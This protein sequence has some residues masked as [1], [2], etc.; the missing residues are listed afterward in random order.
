MSVHELRPAPEVI[1]LHDLPAL[2]MRLHQAEATIH[3]R[4]LWVL[5]ALY[6]TVG[7]EMAEKGQRTR[8]DRKAGVRY[9]LDPPRERQYCGCHHSLLYQCP[10]PIAE[11]PADIVR[12]DARPSFYLT[13]LADDD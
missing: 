7:K 10:T 2:A 8:T 1:E 9:H 4:Y 11:R 13:A 12:I 3:E 6:N 5:S